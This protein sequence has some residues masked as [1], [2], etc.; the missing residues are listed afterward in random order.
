MDVLAL[1]QAGV[2]NAVAPLG[3]AFTERQARRLRRYVE[4]GILF[5][6]G[7]DAGVKAAEKSILVCE[8]AGIQVDVVV[9]EPG[10]D[11]AE[12]LNDQGA[13]ALHKMLKY[14]INSF[15]YLLQ[16]ARERHE[17]DSPEGKEAI[18]RDIF[19]YIDVV[20]SEVRKETY[21]SLVADA[22]GVETGAIRRDLSR[23]GGAGV[24]RSAD[25]PPERDSA[26][27]RDLYLLLALSVNREFFPYVRARVSID[28]L[29]DPRGKEL[30]VALEECYRRGEESI[31]A[32]LNAVDDSRLRELIVEK[33][34]SD[35]FGRNQERSIKEAVSR[36]RERS[37]QRQRK[38]VLARLKRAQ[39]SGLQED[40]IKNLQLDI[41]FFDSELQKLKVNDND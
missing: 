38:E 8:K 41:M 32:L 12:I 5:F 37:L 13:E 9:S 18:C 19:P 4:R 27:S 23:H 39:A 40:D 22:L 6:D 31:D 21:V 33:H 7:D 17:G 15:E 24:S 36:L 11:P 10:S 3:T 2:R 35:E 20:D 30:F 16:K 28:D 25:P 1:H 26:I 34:S 14:P 29:E